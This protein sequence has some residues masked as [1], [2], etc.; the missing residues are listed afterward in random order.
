M[1]TL[2]GISSFQ[3]LAMFRRGLFYSYLAIYLRH[4][5]GM[6][7]TETTLFA[8]LPMLFNVLAQRYV[9]GPWS[10]R[11]QKR[12]SLIIWGEFLAG[13]GTI[14][15]W[16]LHRIPEDKIW[17]GWIVIAGLT[18]IEIFWAMSNIGWS[19]LISD[20]YDEGNRGKIIGKLEGLGGLGRMAG[21]FGGGLLYDKLGTEFPGWGF[22]DGW[23]FFFSGIV[24][25]LSIFPLLMLPEGGIKKTTD[26]EINLENSS[27]F[28]PSDFVMFILAMTLINFSRNS[29]A[30]SIAQYFTLNPGLHMS[31]MT[32][33]YFVNIRSVGFIVAGFF[34]GWLLKKLGDQKLLIGGVLL[35]AT[36]LFQLG[37]G[38]TLFE[39]GTSSLLM[40]ISEVFI[41][42]AAYQLASVYIPAEKR[43]KL[44]S[45]FNA[46]FFLSWGVA[47]TLITGPVTDLLIVAGHPEPFA[48]RVSFNVAAAIT[49]T[50]LLLL[51]FQFRSERRR[52][53]YKTP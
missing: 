19:A 33:S 52:T 47:G 27:S 18:I 50:G 14:L 45:V 34:T 15:L 41:M 5:L 7:V 44:F 9:W 32:L 26:L 6:S 10:D 53:K 49:L 31:A 38:N 8:T 23:L 2:L 4:F 43:G 24:M 16:F 25:F 22:Y 12:R 36:S 20:L 39:I 30:V 29:V 48:Y 40:G 1:K 51:L 46:T 17:A 13:I 21:I 37:I 11:Y 3:L 28:H 35:A 42:A